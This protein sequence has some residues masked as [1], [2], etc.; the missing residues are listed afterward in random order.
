MIE[1]G[2][3]GGDRKGAALFNFTG[4]ITEKKIENLQLLRRKEDEDE[5]VSYVIM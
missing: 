4:T 5:C 2:I 1:K 3:E